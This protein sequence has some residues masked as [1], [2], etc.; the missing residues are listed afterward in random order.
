MRGRGSAAGSCDGVVLWGWARGRSAAAPSGW[1]DGVEPE[2]AQEGAEGAVQG[3]GAGR[4]VAMAGSAR[5]ARRSA[6]MEGAVSGRA[7]RSQPGRRGRRADAAGRVGGRGG[8]RDASGSGAWAVGLGVAGTRTPKLLM[9]VRWMTR[10]ARRKNRVCLAASGSVGGGGGGGGD[11]ADEGHQRGDEAVGEVEG[12]GR[13]HERKG[14]HIWVGVG[15]GWVRMVG[16]GV[17]GGCRRN[18]ADDGLARL[19]QGGRSAVAAISP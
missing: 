9:R 18:G 12:G 2:A 5:R 13:E 8:A 17:G 10:R 3:G 6:A 14:E 7:A 4:R 11:G 19:R 16:V 15:K 1:R